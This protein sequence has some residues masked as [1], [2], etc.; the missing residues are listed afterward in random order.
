M[1]MVAEAMTRM[2]SVGITVCMEITAA[3]MKEERVAS[4]V[5][6]TTNTCKVGAET[7]ISVL[8]LFVQTRLVAKL[9]IRAGEAFMMVNEDTARLE[10]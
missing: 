4:A 1:E 8:D 9:Q 10:T 2:S 7:L 5:L 6:A 3:K